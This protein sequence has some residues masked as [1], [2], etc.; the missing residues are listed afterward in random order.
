MM[1]PGTAEAAVLAA[2][3]ANRAAGTAEAWDA[4]MRAVAAFTAASAAAHAVVLAEREVARVRGLAAGWDRLRA[5]TAPA[6][7]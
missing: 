5:L 3:A 1:A 2:S 6:A 4:Y 7:A